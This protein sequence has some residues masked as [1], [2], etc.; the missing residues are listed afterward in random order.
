M[1]PL[2]FGTLLLRQKLQVPGIRQKPPNCRVVCGLK[3][4]SAAEGAICLAG[5]GDQEC[6]TSLSLLGFLCSTW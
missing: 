4:P 1:L 2:G 6:I 5:R 3:A